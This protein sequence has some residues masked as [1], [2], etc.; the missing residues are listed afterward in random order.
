MRRFILPAY[1]FWPLAYLAT[2]AVSV[3][4]LWWVI[5]IGGNPFTFR[6]VAAVDMRGEAGGQF[7]PGTIVGIRRQICA[8]TAVRLH[9]FPVLRSPSGFSIP[10]APSLIDA[11]S[12]CSSLVYG[13]VLPKVPAGSYTFMSTARFQNNLVGRDEYVSFPAIPIEVVK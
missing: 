3:M 4:V 8:D 2:L 7:R 5:L 12:G 10:L 13:F 11:A 6:D 9:V 1:V